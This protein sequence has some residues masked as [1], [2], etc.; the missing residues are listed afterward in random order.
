MLYDM[1]KKLDDNSNWKYFR[2]NRMFEKYTELGYTENN[3]QNR[4][5]EQMNLMKPLII[6]IK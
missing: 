2:E 3:Y 4:I 5:E 6:C 1:V